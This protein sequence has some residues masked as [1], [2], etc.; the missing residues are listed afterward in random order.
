MTSIELNNV[1]VSFPV[2]SAGARSL[3]NVVISATTGGRIG[4]QSN[5]LIVQALD[6]VSLK[7]EHGDRVALVGHNGA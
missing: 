3:K 2:Y 5:H 7:F 4:N 1:S 6:N